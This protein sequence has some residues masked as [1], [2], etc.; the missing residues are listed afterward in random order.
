M[1]DP[2]DMKFWAWTD[3]DGTRA[4]TCDNVKGYYNPVVNICRVAIAV[5]Y[6]NHFGP[7]ASASARGRDG[8]WYMVVPDENEHVYEIDI[9]FFDEMAA[10]EFKMRW[11]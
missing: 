8:R 11:V 5:W 3:D 2:E 9:Y 1:F 7:R 10:F 4:F 6:W